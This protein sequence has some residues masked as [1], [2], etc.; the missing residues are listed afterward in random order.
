MKKKRNYSRGV[1]GCVSNP[2]F[3]IVLKLNFLLP[4][5]G[6]MLGARKKVDC[7]LE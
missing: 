6:K 3:G 7:G 5:G 2:H 4:I 1:V